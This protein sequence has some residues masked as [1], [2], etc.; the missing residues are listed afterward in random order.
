MK[1][2]KLDL[3]KSL[4]QL[5]KERPQQIIPPDRLPLVGKERDLCKKT[6]KDLSIDDIRFLINH[7]IGLTLLVPIAIDVLTKNPFEAGDCY[8]GGLLSAVLQVKQEF[9]RENRDLYQKAEEILQR[10]ERV[11]TEEAKESLTIFLPAV[12]YKFRKFQPNA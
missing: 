1:M 11:E 6:I 8:E 4:Q 12:I 2:N 9:W 3:R 10:A 5:E 7:K